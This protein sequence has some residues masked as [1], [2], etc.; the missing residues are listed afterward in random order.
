VHGGADPVVTLPSAQ[1]FASRMGF[2]FYGYPEVGQLVLYQDAS[3]VLQKVADLVQA[4][5]R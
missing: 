4:T 1:A 5:S 3:D 2:T